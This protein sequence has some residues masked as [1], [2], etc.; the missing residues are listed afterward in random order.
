M[1]EGHARLVTGLFIRPTETPRMRKLEPNHQVIRGAVALQMGLFEDPHEFRQPRLVFLNDDD[2]IRI[3]PPIGPNGHRFR[4]ADE[5][6]AA[7]TKPLP[8]PAHF[9]GH[10]T[11]RRPVPTFHGMDREAIA[12]S[13]SVNDNVGDG[14]DQCRLR[15]SF[16][17]I[18]TRDVD[19]QRRHML[20]EVSH[21]LE[22]R[23]TGQFE[24]FG[25]KSYFR[26]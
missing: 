4:P 3:R 8:A 10:A 13:L 17:G 25:H 11:G 9:L 24:R 5:L 1:P 14:L 23:N 7:F 26:E 21:R 2:L 6:G 18:L 15:A 12:N 19:I 20:A 22:R 16:N